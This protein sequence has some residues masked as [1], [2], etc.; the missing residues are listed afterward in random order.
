MQADK[1]VKLFQTLAIV[2]LNMGNLN[3]EMGSLKNRLAT[4]KAIL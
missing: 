1:V 4:K 3:L 2:S